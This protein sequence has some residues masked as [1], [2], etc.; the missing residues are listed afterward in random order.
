EEYRD[1]P[2]PPRTR[3]GEAPIEVASGHDGEPALP[4]TFV[5]YEA[6]PREYGLSVAQTLLR[7]HTRVADLYSEPMDQV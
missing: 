6:A 3:H 7:V 4:G 2:R 1:A 5:D